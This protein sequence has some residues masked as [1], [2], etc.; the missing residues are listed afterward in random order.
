M[1]LFGRLVLQPFIRHC[2][3]PVIC[4]KRDKDGN[5]SQAIYRNTNVSGPHACFVELHRCSAT[6]MR[7]RMRS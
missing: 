5:T 4:Y 6:G 7:I 2:P 1:Q 3:V